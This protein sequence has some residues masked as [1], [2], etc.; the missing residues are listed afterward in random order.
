MLYPASLYAFR[1]NAVIKTKPMKYLLYTGV[2]ALLI[3]CCYS[4]NAK[5]HRPGKTKNREIKVLLKDSV[6][7]NFPYDQERN[8]TAIYPIQYK[9]SN[10]ILQ[11]N[12]RS[13]YTALTGID[14]ANKNQYLVLDTFK[15]IKRVYK[16]Q[17]F[18][19]TNADSIWAVSPEKGQI[20]LFSMEGRLR[21]TIPL[22]LAFDHKPVDLIARMRGWPFAYSSVQQQ[23]YYPILS[24]YGEDSQY[25][26]QPKFATIQ[27][28]KDSAAITNV[29][30]AFPNAYTNQFL[31][32]TNIPSIYTFAGKTLVNYYLSDSL[33]AYTDG[34]PAQAY[35]AHSAVVDEP[36][37][38]FDPAQSNNKDYINEFAFSYTAYNDLV[39][40]HASPYLFRTVEHKS[41][42]YNADSTINDPVD[43]PWSI[44]VLNASL[45]IV[46][47]INIGPALI[48]RIEYMPYAKG[49]WGRSLQ[50]NQYYYYEMQLDE[51]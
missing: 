32:Y 20:Y 10:W 6:T 34:K 31:G 9:G 41:S 8:Y 2:L 51:L 4:C 27:L 43:K 22:N 39:T 7:N 50:T 47:E 48:N 40:N 46:G 29:F 3:C 33:Y 1:D 37:R 13:G 12:T 28:Q 14:K 42:F 44:V 19:Y 36:E 30:G 45:Q 38:L 18:E 25:F 35:D 23:F 5:G 11:G 15:R 26:R 49:F 17:C 24:L 16:I 21:K